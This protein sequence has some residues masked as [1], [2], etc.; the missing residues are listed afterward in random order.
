[1]RRVASLLYSQPDIREF[2]TVILSGIVP[3]MIRSGDT[4]RSRKT[5]LDSTV[6]GKGITYNVGGPTDIYS[7]ACESQGL[8]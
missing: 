3:M 8:N 4:F 1:M 2:S 7:V 6:Y 5:E